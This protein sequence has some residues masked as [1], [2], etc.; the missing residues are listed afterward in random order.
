MADLPKINN[1]I[2]FE[3]VQRIVSENGGGSVF[4]LCYSLQ[5]IFQNVL[6]NSNPASHLVREDLIL[7]AKNL[8][9]QKN[10][11]PLSLDKWFIFLHMMPLNRA[12]C[13]NIFIQMIKLC[14]YTKFREVNFKILAQILISPSLLALIRKNP[15]LSFCTWC[16]GVANLEHILISCSHMK[17]FKNVFVTKNIKLLKKVPKDK[18]WIFGF[19][20]S[21]YN[22]IAWVMNF[23]IYKI[24]LRACSSFC[25][26]FE[27]RVSSEFVHFDK[28]FPIL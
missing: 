23:A 18:H 3:A 11:H 27:Q 15:A 14:K 17:R 2:N 9:V 26:N 24:Y 19:K 8:F 22:L 6:T 1:K 28:I 5:N 20:N 12:E 16:A 10:C 21:T 13:Q 25:N 7:S 4:L